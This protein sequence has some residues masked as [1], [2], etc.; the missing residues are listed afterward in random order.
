MFYILLIM[1]SCNDID[2][3]IIKSIKRLNNQLAIQEANECNLNYM[4]DLELST[5]SCHFHSQKNESVIKPILFKTKTTIEDTDDSNYS[6]IC[7]EKQITDIDMMIIKNKDSISNLE[8]KNKEMN[9]KIV[10]LNCKLDKL[11][12][13][14]DKKPSKSNQLSSHEILRFYD[15][16]KYILIFKKLYKAKHTKNSIILDTLNNVLIEEDNILDKN[17]QF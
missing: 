9:I 4:D 1:N 10:E 11:E 17:N 16:V 2:S 3:F 12:Q 15:M 14:I 5:S 7:D 13:S 8:M 6:D